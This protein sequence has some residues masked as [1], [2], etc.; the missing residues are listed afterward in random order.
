M[1]G[2]NEYFS[3][4][5]SLTQGH[6]RPISEEMVSPEGENKLPLPFCLTYSYS[7]L[8]FLAL[9][10]GIVVRNNDARPCHWEA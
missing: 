7:H 3:P 6:G 9:R 10:I 8:W 4:Y 2:L 1:A 5:K